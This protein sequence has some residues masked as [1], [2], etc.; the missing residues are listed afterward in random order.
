MNTHRFTED[1]IQ[2]E[3]YLAHC[4]WSEARALRF[5]PASELV[6]ERKTIED[7]IAELV[8]LLEMIDAHTERATMARLPF[9]RM[10]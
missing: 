2:P 10:H 7:T 5:M 6:F 1:T 8:G 4:V 9:E 3:E